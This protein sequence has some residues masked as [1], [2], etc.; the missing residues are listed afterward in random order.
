[1]RTLR[2]VA[3]EI[4]TML[5]R[6]ARFG[7]SCFIFAIVAGCLDKSASMKSADSIRNQSSETSVACFSAS[8]I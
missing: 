5:T 7:V 1:M 6:F 4:A 8:V 3:A 2:R